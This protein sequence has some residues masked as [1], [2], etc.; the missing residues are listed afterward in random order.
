[1]KK[2]YFFTAALFFS[3]GFTLA[4]STPKTQPPKTVGVILSG[5]GVMDGAEISEAVLTLLAI[6]QAGAKAIIMAPNIPQKQVVNHLT[7]KVMPGEKR[8]VLVEAARIAR[9][10]IRDVKSVSAK[11]LDALILPGGYGVAKNL[12]DFAFKGT[13]CSV[14]PDVQKLILAMHAAKKPMGFI[15][16]SPVLAAKV[17]G[18]FHPKLTIGSDKK[19]MEAIR[20]LGGI[21]EVR[22]VTQICVDAK[23][24]VVSTPA[25]M[26]GPNIARVAK[27][28]KN[29]VNQVLKMTR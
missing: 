10:K 8:N 23:N 9:G 3:L 7:G 11:E 18:K 26:L 22:S 15:C 6:D 29:L 19:T 24:R 27:G 13:D 5:C 1:M 2:R 20:K 17:L 21:P 25:Y 4:W 12:C 28:I 16:I 14:N